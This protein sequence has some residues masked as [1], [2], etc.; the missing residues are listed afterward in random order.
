MRRYSIN[1]LIEYS[2]LTVIYLFRTLTFLYETKI[3]H[4]I[5]PTALSVKQ[6]HTDPKDRTEKHNLNGAENIR[7]SSKL[8]NHRQICIKTL[9]IKLLI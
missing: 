1:M 3:T 8:L 2:I 7:C 5:N 6:N 4:L 9:K